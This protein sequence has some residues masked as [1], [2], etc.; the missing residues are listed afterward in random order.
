MKRR[1]RR[2]PDRAD[3]LALLFDSSG[4]ALALLPERTRGP[5]ERELL[6]AEMSRY[7]GPGFVEGKRPKKEKAT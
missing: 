3:M 2:S 7:S 5:T 6:V 1:L 4:D